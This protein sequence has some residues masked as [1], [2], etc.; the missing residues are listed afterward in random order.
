MCDIIILFT[1]FPEPGSCKT[2]LIPALGKGGAAG[3]HRQLVAKVLNE[4][5]TLQASREFKL[6]IFYHGGSQ[7]AMEQW[8]GTGYWFAPQSGGDLGEKMGEA[9]SQRSADKG[10]ALL[11]G[12][13]CPE[14][15]P[16]LFSEAFDALEKNRLVFGPA[17]D[18]GYYLIGIRRN[19]PEGLIRPLFSDIDWGSDSVLSRTLK[20]AR[21][22]N[23]SYHLLPTRH[24]IDTPDD[25]RHISNHPY[26]Q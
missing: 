21:Q 11:I 3:L 9:L 18:G 2:R 12:S 6:E 22:L 5:D 8:L 26:F 10:K 14:L 7:E 17:A 16:N 24:D 13:D 1:R 25:L 15:D 20:T 4:L 19:L 23:L